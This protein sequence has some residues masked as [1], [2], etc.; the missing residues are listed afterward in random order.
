MTEQFNIRDRRGNKRYFIDNILLR[1]GWGKAIGP[2]GI[3]VYNAL[4]IHADADSQDCWPSHQTIADLTGMSRRQ[5]VREVAKLEAYNIIASK[6]SENYDS[7]T[8]ILL[9]Y[10]E[11]LPVD[12]IDVTHSHRGCDRESQGD[13]TGSHTNKTQVNKTQEQHGADAPPAT[14]A[15]ELAF[16]E[17]MESAE[18]PPRDPP[19]D[20]DEYRQRVRESEAR[21]FERIAGEPWLSWGKESKWFMSEVA[22]YN[23]R[24]Q[25]VQRL[26]YELERQFTFGPTWGNLTK[27]KQWTSGLVSCL[28]ETRGRIEPVRQ[29]MRQARESGLTIG[30]PHG[31]VNICH[32]LVSKQQGK[33]VIARL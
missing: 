27:V 3:A 17:E 11:W 12:A 23:G 14:S 6:P 24:G 15:D 1:G 19:K 22:K 5:V 31:L 8:Y 7:K 30:N 28:E 2:Y 26:G 33:K 29:A 21:M 18:P 16:I 13:V 4:C 25:A 9:A 20:A 32:D 10:D